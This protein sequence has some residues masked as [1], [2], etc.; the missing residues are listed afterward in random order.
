MFDETHG[1]APRSCDTGKSVGVRVWV[2][3]MLRT[4]STKDLSDRR[5]PDLVSMGVVAGVFSPDL[6]DE[7]IVECD[8]V[9]RRSCTLLSIVEFVESDLS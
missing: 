9:Q 2:E 3:G 7:V 6:V 5:L 8:R 1:Q 4:G